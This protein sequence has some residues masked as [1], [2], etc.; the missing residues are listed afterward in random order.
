M[1]CADMARIP[2]PPEAHA[3]VHRP[4]PMDEERWLSCATDMA[5]AGKEAAQPLYG[6]ASGRVVIGQ[7]AGGDSTMEIDRACE[8][9]IHEVLRAKA[10]FPHRLISEESGISGPV[11]APWRVVVDPLDG[12][13]NAKRGLEPFGT[14]IAVADGATLG[15]V[16]VGYIEDFLRPHTFSAI[17]G[18]GLIAAGAPGEKTDPH[19]FELDLVEIVLLEAGR[20]DRHRF[21]YHDLSAMGAVG[22]SRDMRIRQIGSLALSL[23]YVAVGVADILVAA[24]RSRSVDLAAG[25]LILSEAGGAAA[26]LAG[27]D[28]LAQPLDLEKRC[29]FVAWRAGLDGT[30]IVARA[31]GLREALTHA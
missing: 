11:D 20:P 29:A 8:E 24:V 1:L 25:L 14:S 5:A 21:Q 7:G 3:R 12:S 18:S 16:R 17:K 19:R 27:E 13:L 2:I 9:A 10:P 31:R 4:L 15:D 23:C 6:R 30:E 28:V 22:R 26:T